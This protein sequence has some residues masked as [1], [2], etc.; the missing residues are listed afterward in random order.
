[1]WPALTTRHDR[2]LKHHRR[3]RPA[4]A[5]ALLDGAG[6][7]RTRGGGLFHSLLAVRAAEKLGELVRSPRQGL[8]SL[9]WG[10]GRLLS[11]AVAWALAA[12]NNFSTWAAD[13]GMDLPGLSWWALCTRT[14]SS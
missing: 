6:L 12:D 10:G 14:T 1:A 7:R 4:E 3:Y 2:R 8:P 13:R 9:A 5:R 11:T